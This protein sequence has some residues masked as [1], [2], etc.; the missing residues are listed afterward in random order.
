MSTLKRLL[1][2][3]LFA[4][5]SSCSGGLNIFASPTPVPP[6]ST[7]LPPTATPVPL[8]LSVNGEGISIDEFDAELAR[9]QAAQTALGNHPSD[10]VAAGPVIDEFVSQLL[11]AQGAV[12]AGFTLDAAA[13]QARVDAL[14]GKLGGADKLSTWEQAHGYTDQSFRTALKRETAAAWMR[15]K[16]TSGVPSTAEQIHVRQ[17][18]LYNQDSAQRIWAELQAG[19]DFDTLA[20][21]VDPVTLGDIGWFPRGYLA[22]K[23]VEDAAFA[24]EPGKYSAVIQ[25]Q[26]GFHIVELIERQAARPLSPDERLTLQNHA[27]EDWLATHRQ[28]SS[29]VLAPK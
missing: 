24:L 10:Q 8:A 23:P 6:T 15:D 27:V 28:Q 14:A 12:Q 17:I 22:E 3:L 2:I 11:L 25:D 9:Y 20:A 7:P 29:V 26:I 16:I 21:E 19:S 18:L 4:L 1:F 13:L 5:L